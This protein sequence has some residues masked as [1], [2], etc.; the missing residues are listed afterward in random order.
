MNLSLVLAAI[1]AVESGGRNVVSRTGDVGPA[2]MSPAA[3]VEDGTP[4][5][6]LARLARELPQHGM[7]VNIYTMALAWRAPTRAYR[8]R[9]TDADV[10]YAERVRR[11]YL[12]P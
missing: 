3:I 5:R 9:P 2:Q 4:E 12:C 1:I 6:R 7:P 11:I 8:G 10:R